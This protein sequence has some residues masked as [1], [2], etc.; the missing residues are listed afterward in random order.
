ML[1]LVGT[2]FCALLCLLKLVGAILLFPLSYFSFEISSCFF[3]FSYS[4]FLSQW[5][6]SLYSPSALL[7]L[8]R[9]IFALS[10]SCALECQ[11]LLGGA[12]SGALVFMSKDPVFLAASQGIPLGV[13]L[14]A[15]RSG[16]LAFLGLKGL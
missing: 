14:V 4:I 9:T 7:Q 3:L 13:P 1:Q 10:L 6:P 12:P 8:M 15:W 5:M 11:Y 2:I 16:G